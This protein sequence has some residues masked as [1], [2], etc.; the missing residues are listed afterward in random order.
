MRTSQLGRALENLAENAWTAGSDGRLVTYLPV[1]DSRGVDRA[2]ALGGGPPLFVQIKGHEHP[3]LDGRLSFA[4]PLAAIGAYD[5]WAALLLHGNA[6]RLEEA[7]LIPSFDL[8]RL[9]ERGRTAD[10]RDCLHVTLSPTSPTFEE[11]LVHPDALGSRLTTMAGPVLPELARPPEREPEPPERSQEMGAY[12]EE[13][14][15]AAI[16]GGSDQLAVYR[17]AVDVGRDL[18]VQHAGTNSFVYLQIK[19]TERQDR[20]GLARFQVRRRTFTRDAALVYLFCYRSPAATA[21]GPLWLVSSQELDAIAAHGDN[22]H[23]SFEA[24]LDGPDRRWEDRRLSPT[25]LSSRL[26]HLLSSVGGVRV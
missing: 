10:G 2:I 14:V 7:Y 13:S 12:F 15:V 11:F 23:I 26:L 1:L 9:G 25:D 20:P 8:L 6:E 22:D 3:R 17:P 4:I 19:G 5:R 16:Y 21:I 24:H 18:L